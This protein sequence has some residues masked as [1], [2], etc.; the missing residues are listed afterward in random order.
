ME[1]STGRWFVFAGGITGAA[2][3]ALSAVAAHR[4]GHDIGIAASFLVM[5]APA[6]LAAGLSGRNRLLTIG[7][8]KIGP[9]LK[10]DT[11]VTASARSSGVKSIRSSIETPCR[12]KAGGLVTNF[13]VGCAFSPGTSD[14]A[15]AR[16]S[17][18]QIG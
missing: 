13:C 3:V 2:G 6:L 11:S 16:S 17:I 10:R 5:H 18:G 15:T 9:I 1:T 8:V 4:G 12:S 7:G 14:G